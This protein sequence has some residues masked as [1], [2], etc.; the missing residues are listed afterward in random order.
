MIVLIGFMGA[1]KTTVGRLLAAKLGLPFVDT[2]S[3]IEGRAGKPVRQVFQEDG[4]RAFRTL[5]RAVVREVLEG[6]EAIV[7]LG[8]GALGDPAMRASL[9]WHTPVLLEVGYAEAMKRIGEDPGRP[10]LAIRDPKALYEDREP[11]Y[12]NVAEMV[13]STHDK[14]PVKVAEEV[15]RAALPQGSDP[16]DHDRIVVRT[17]AG[18]YD[19][20]IGWEIADRLGELIRDRLR[21][22]KAFVVTHPSLD[23]IATRL[24]VSLKD[25][26]LPVEV[27]TLD[28]GEL[29]KS[30]EKVIE[31]YRELAAKDAHRRDL[32]VAVGGGVVTDVAGFVAST[33]NRGMSLINV[34]TTLLG[35]VDAAIGGKNGVNLAE[36]KNLVGTIYQPSLVVCDPELLRGLPDEELTSGTAE[37]AKYGFVADPD[38]LSVLET[39]AQ[40]IFDGDRDVLCEIVSRSVAIKASYVSADERDRG[41]RA[42][43][44]YGH[45]FAHAIETVDAYS[46]VRHGEAVALGMMAAAHL[47]H[48][49]G[50]IDHEVV[51]VH[52]RTLELLRL[53]TTASLDLAELQRAWVHDKKY[54]GGPRFV[55]LAALGKAEAGIEVPESA[56]RAAIER[57]AH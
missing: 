55:L 41:V 40:R 12:R 20:L 25:I 21:P 9:E 36:G 11:L 23:R 29:S 19:V 15:A 32:M 7:A 24:L 2:D 47:A 37:V 35:Q 43:L 27:L 30:L 57:M 1:G 54:E 3:V 42:H 26:D 4:E 22:E 10:L 45:T 6:A 52:R 34:P 31:L 50:R 44:N 16:S 28:E 46:S 51:D 33:F 38:L 13:V 17:P 18:N 53:P 14:S 39:K 8:G 48:E 56:L 5:E 49:L